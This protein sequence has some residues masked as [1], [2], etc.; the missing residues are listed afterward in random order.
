[1]ISATF[2]RNSA[3]TSAGGRD[4]RVDEAGLGVALAIIF[5]LDILGRSMNNGSLGD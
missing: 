4:V 2:R 5:P 3:S 1:L